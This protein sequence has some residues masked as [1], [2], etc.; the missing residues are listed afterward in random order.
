[1]ILFAENAQNYELCDDINFFTNIILS[2]RY[3][4]LSTFTWKM[5]A[6]MGLPQGAEGIEQF[7]Y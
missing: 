2:K 6:L 7:G 5:N 4:S 1:V 3:V